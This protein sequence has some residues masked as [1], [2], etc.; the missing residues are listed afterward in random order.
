MLLIER[1]LHLKIVIVERAFQFKGTNREM[2]A[3]VA[4]LYEVNCFKALEPAIYSE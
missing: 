4:K 2:V 3:T 1:I